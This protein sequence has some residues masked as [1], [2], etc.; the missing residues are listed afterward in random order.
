LSYKAA[1]PDEIG[2]HPRFCGIKGSMGLS[3]G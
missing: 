2:T 3:P 1:R